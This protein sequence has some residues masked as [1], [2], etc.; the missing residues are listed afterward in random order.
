MNKSLDHIVYL[1]HKAK[2]ME[3]LLSW[4]KTMIIRS[5][6]G[7]KLPHWR[8]N[9]GDT[10]YFIN[11]NWEWLIKARATVSQVFN[12]EKMTEEESKTLV[13]NN[14]NKLQL[15]EK[16]FEKWAWKRYI[17][18]IEVKNIEEIEYFSIDRSNYWNMDDWLLVEDIEGIK[19]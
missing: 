1:D 14:Q 11:N 19:K 15:T 5:A 4:N 18:L 7:R 17:V 16:Q 9:G 13:K 12:S 10:L 2:E 6:T 8:V 3:N